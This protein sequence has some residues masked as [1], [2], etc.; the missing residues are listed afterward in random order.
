MQKWTSASSKFGTTVTEIT[1]NKSQKGSISKKHLKIQAKTPILKFQKY[2]SCTSTYHYIYCP[3]DI[4]FN[5]QDVCFGM[6]DIFLLLLSE[7]SEIYIFFPP[8]G[9]KNLKSA[10]NRKFSGQRLH[11]LADEIRRGL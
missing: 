6:E 4:F 5:N 11:Y 3:K 1:L 8:S 2:S 10:S 7:N 9:P